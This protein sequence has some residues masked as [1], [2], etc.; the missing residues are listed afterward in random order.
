VDR[1]DA[2]S[3]FDSRVPPIGVH[4]DGETI[5]TEQADSIGDASR[6]S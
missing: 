4:G 6:R 2:K 3:A 1:F 5:S